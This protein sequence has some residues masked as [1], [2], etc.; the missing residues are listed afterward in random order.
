MA[1]VVIALFGLVNFIE[2][3]G[4][5]Y[6]TAIN[7]NLKGRILLQVEKEGEAWYVHPD[8]KKRFYLGRPSEAFDI[9]REQGLGVSNGDLI[10]FKESGCPNRLSGKILLQVEDKGQAYYVY[11]ETLE[12][13]YLGRPADAFKIMRGLGLGISNSNLSK[14]DIDLDSKKLPGNE[15]LSGSCGPE[16][17]LGN[18]C[19]QVSLTGS[20]DS[21]QIEKEEGKKESDNVGEVDSQTSYLKQRTHNRVNDY[22]KAVGLSELEWDERVAKIAGDQSRAMASGKAD[23]S[24]DGFYDRADQIGEFMVIRRAGENLAYNYGVSDPAMR[25]V[26][27]WIG[28]PGHKKNM[29]GDYRITG[30]GVAKSDDGRYYFTQLFVK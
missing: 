23:F 13:H 10:E 24:H 11:P 28:S 8:S 5:V 6:A 9:M 4:K 19:E 3:S 26:S 25:A 16:V 29:E 27:Q 2:V 22:R 7:D 20:T 12:L 18:N 21:Q 15:T 14:I 17:I 1:I 30:I